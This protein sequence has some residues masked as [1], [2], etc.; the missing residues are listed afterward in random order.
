MNQVAR[1]YDVECDVLR[2][3]RQRD[4]LGHR[5]PQ[6]QCFGDTEDN[7]TGGYQFFTN[8]GGDYRGNKMK[9]RLG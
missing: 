3:A 9:F 1:W 2:R 5:E 6:K 7:G 8:G 4:L